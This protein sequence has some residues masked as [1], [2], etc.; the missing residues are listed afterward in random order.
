VR[1]RGA[2]EIEKVRTTS[3]IPDDTTTPNPASMVRNSFGRPFSI[4]FPSF[5]VSKLLT[6]PETVTKGNDQHGKRIA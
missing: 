2:G 3:V 1:E 5:R 6:G 4:L